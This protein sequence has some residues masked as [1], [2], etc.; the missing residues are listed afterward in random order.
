VVDAADYVV[1]RNGPTNLVNEGA[2]P[3][4]VDMQDYEFWRSRFGAAASAAAGPSVGSGLMAAEA[5]EPATWLMMV[6]LFVL[7]GVIHRR[8]A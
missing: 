8:Q 3:N 1:W 7:A 5:P 6:G 2:S 4:V